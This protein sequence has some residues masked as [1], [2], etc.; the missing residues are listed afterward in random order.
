MG[1][2]M[3]SFDDLGMAVCKNGTRLDDDRAETLSS[4]QA[5]PVV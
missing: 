2:P 1:L 3:T 4:C 5:E